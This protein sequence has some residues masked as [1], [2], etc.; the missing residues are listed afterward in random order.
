MGTLGRTTGKKESL[1]QPVLPR[2]EV[3]G[4]GQQGIIL[5]PRQ[6]RLL[7]NEPTQRK[8]APRERERERER[9]HD[10]MTLTLFDLWMARSLKQEL[11]LDFADT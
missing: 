5:S 7:E 6:K 11:P 1:F 9:H 10:M 3:V 4:L 2:R 8:V